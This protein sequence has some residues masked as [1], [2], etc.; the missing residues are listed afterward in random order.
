MK[1]TNDISIPNPCHADWNKMTSKKGG[2]V[3]PAAEPLLIL[4][5]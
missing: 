3:H 2:I 1:N 4:L 5:A